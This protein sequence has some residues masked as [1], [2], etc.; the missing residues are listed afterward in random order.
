MW[1]N[2]SNFKQLDWKS[3][4]KKLWRFLDCATVY[5][6]FNNDKCFVFFPRRFIL[7]KN[8]DKKNVFVGSFRTY[9]SELK[10]QEFFYISKFEDLQFLIIWFSQEIYQKIIFAISVQ[11]FQYMHIQKFWDKTIFVFFCFSN[12]FWNVKTMNILQ[13]MQNTKTSFF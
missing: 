13:Y 3:I 10:C 9:F 5:S 7:P 4:D 2:M 8:L 6:T 11:M 1:A 12:Q